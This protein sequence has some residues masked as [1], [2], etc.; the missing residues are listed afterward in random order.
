LLRNI[1]SKARYL[2]Y[3]REMKMIKKM[4]PQIILLVALFGFGMSANA[5]LLELTPGSTDGKDA[6]ISNGI[7]SDN[8][9][10]TY[11]D[12]IVNWSG[13]LRSIGLIEFDLSVIP[14]NATINSAT[15][16]LFQRNNNNQNLYTYDLFRVTSSW[17]ESTVTFNSRPSLDPTAVASLLIPDGNRNLYRNSEDITSLVSGW[18]DGTYD[19][20]GMWIEEIP[21]QGDAY[22]YFSSSDGIEGQRPIFRANYSVPKP[23]PEPTTLALFGLGL[24]GLGFARR[25]KST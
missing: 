23:V 13:N 8:N 1:E 16:S 18:I 9:Y 24:A 12:L 15:L 7:T 11:T 21:I 14:S 5:I 3:C 6:Q 17:D 4:T 2:I 22:A 10:G 20:Y 19:N 25:R